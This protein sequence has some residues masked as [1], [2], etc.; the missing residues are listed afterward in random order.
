MNPSGTARSCSFSSCR[1]GASTAV[2]GTPRCFG[3]ATG[4]VHTVAERRPELLVRILQLLLDIVDDATRLRRID[5]PLGRERGGVELAYRCMVLDPPRHQRLGVRRFVLLVVAE[6]PV[7]D[8]VDDHVLAEALPERHRQPDRR[9]RRFGVV[10]VDMDDR[11]V[12]TLGEIARVPGR[13]TLLGIRREAHLVVGDEMQRS[14]GRVAVEG[15]EV[16]GLGDDALAREAPRR[17][18]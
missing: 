3:A 17:R 9:D 13:T 6:A 10:G 16:E 18:G 4:S 14:P 11:H 7:A 15:L 8:E 1:I 2:S 12:E 5:D